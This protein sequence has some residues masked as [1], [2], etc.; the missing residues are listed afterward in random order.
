MLHVAG[1][2]FL[3]QIAAYCVSAVAGGTMFRRWWR[4]DGEGRRRVWRLYGWFSGLMLC[5]S[6]FVAVDS[7]AGMQVLLLIFKATND[8]SSTPNSAQFFASSAVYHRWAAAFVITY[9]MDF[10]CLSVAKLMVLDRMM[11][12]A[13][14]LTRQADG[15]SRRWVVGG[16]IVMAAVVAVNVVGLGG[17]VAAAVYFVQ[18]ADFNSAASTMYA[19]NNSAEATN[20]VNLGL[21]QQQLGLTSQSVQMFCEA[22]VLLLIIVA[23]AV[24]GAACAHRVSSVLLDMTS[25]AAAAGRQ[26][27]LQI[28]C[29]TAFVFVTFLL[30]AVYSTMNALAN[31]LQDSAQFSSCPNPCD[32]SCFNVYELMRVWLRHTPEFQIMV[33]LISSPLSMLVA[34]WGMTSGRTLQLMQSNRR[35]MNTMRASMLRGTGAG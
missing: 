27:R 13:A 11:D 35:Q 17:S 30:R 18:T 28:V 3:E 19:A 22:A 14:R 16:R 7:G 32:A 5:G 20:L 25:A 21:Q 2:D 4:M 24:V 8:P 10:F 23:F 15:I 6:I 29:T 31:G 12:F 34:L 1:D 26:L 9:E 33:V